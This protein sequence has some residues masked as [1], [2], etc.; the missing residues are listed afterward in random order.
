MFME[1]QWK[2]IEAPQSVSEAIQKNED[3]HTKNVPSTYT[4]SSYDKRSSGKNIVP[5]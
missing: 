1:T 2:K 4:V 3:H 5:T